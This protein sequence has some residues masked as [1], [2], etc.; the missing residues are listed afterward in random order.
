MGVVYTAHDPRLK[1]Q[2]AIKLLTADLTPDETAKQRFL[3]E[4]QAAS[5]LDHSNI[6]TIYEINEADD[7]Q[8]YLV[9]AYYAGETL[10]QR[11]ERGPLAVD[12]AVDIATQVGLGLSK[13]HAAGI[14]HRDIKPANLIV[15][16][17]GTVK[18]L[19]FGL[20]KLAGTE[21]VTQ[22]GTT[23]GT[24]AYMSPE[25]ARGEEVD[26]RTDIWSLGVVLYEMLAGEPPFRGENLL[27]LSGAIQQDQPPL[28]RGDSASLGGVVVRALSKSHSG[29]YQ[30]VEAEPTYAQAHALIGLV[31]ACRAVLS[32]AAPEQV[33]P[34][35]KEAAL[36]GEGGIS[37][38][39]LCSWRCRIPEPPTSSIGSWQ[40]WGTSGPDSD[41]LAQQA[42]ERHVRRPD[43]LLRPET[44]RC[45]KP[46]QDVHVRFLGAILRQLDNAVID[47]SAMVWL[48][49]SPRHCQVDGLRVLRCRDDQ[50]E[51]DSVAEID[52]LQPE[53]PRAEL[54]G[55][56]TR[57]ELLV[58]A[59]LAG[60]LVGHYGRRVEAQGA[61]PTPEQ[62]ENVEV[63]ADFIAAWNARDVE[64]VESFL[65]EDARF[66]AGRVGSIGPLGPAAQVFRGFIP[67]TR[68]II[69]TVKPESTTAR[70][71][72]VTHERVDE[73]RLQD[74]TTT[75]SGTWFAVF[76]L[77]DRKIVDFIDFQI[78]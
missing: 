70:G 35:A 39:P 62:E 27:A 7:G 15:T 25:Q 42:S 54:A 36:I 28:L 6:C 1:R 30:A 66:A 9:M 76:G 24:V 56:L 34:M 40:R 53:N 32:F 10:K 41:A 63:V 4:A 33:M 52:R 46:A 71:P 17:D 57:R 19:D 23:V 5:A 38:G 37:A 11:I 47:L 45:N 72:I 49:G 22:T 51:V 8:L 59:G 44:V 77:R 65:A 75:G 73:M 13:A 43:P 48:P 50:T 68:S 74:G 55:P 26:H 21:G 14:V 2:V 58:T 64:K 61:Q 16:A 29:R 18:I 20:A 60:A 78:D 3:Q 31:H 69:M 67:Q 12:E